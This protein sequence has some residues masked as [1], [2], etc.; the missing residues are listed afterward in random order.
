[1]RPGHENYERRQAATIE[2]LTRRLDRVPARTPNL[3]LATLLRVVAG[4]DIY[5]L[6]GSTW[7][8]IK[9]SGVTIASV[10]TTV[11]VDPTTYADGLGYGYVRANGA[12]SGPLVWIC[13]GTITLAAGGTA[14]ASVNNAVAANQLVSSINPVTVPCAA[15]GTATVYMISRAG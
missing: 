13:N 14:T 7:K 10:P 9:T 11:P 1:M 15:G 4:N 12:D 2:R 3:A 5:V 6:G 8:G